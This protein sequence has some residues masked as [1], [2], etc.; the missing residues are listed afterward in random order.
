MDAD[1]REVLESVV[2]HLDPLRTLMSPN[3]P[4]QARMF[5]PAEYTTV[6]QA[7]TD[8]NAILKAPRDIQP[9]PFDE[10]YALLQAA[11]ARLAQ[12]WTIRDRLQGN[13]NEYDSSLPNKGIFEMYQIAGEMAHIIR[14]TMDIQKEI[15]ALKSGALQRSSEAQATYD[16]LQMAEEHKLKPLPGTAF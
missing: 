16:I 3:D 1:I 15:D 10:A 4:K 11:D 2:G 7:Y 13:N 8:L 5:T 9:M 6:C 12:V 14:H